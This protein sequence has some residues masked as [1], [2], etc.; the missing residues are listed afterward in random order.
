VLDSVTPEDIRQAARNYFGDK[1]Q[2][3]V[4]LSYKK[5]GGDK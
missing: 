1:N 2:T 5:Q 3:I 4:T